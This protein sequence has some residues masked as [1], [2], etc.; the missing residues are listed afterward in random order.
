MY[1]IYTSLILNPK[2]IERIDPPK[3]EIEKPTRAFLFNA[4]YL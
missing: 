4:S 1:E 3:G 2:T